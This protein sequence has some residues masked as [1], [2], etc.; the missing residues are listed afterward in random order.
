[1]NV[2]FAHVIHA[3]IQ[4]M[5]IMAT[6][7][8]EGFGAGGAQ[9]LVRFASQWQKG[10]LDVVADAL[11]A[12]GLCTE[13]DETSNT[14]SN[15]NSVGDTARD[16]LHTQTLSRTARPGEDPVRLC[17]ARFTD[18]P[19][20]ITLITVSWPETRRYSAMGRIRST[21]GDGRP[22]SHHRSEREDA[23]RHSSI[24]PRCAQRTASSRS[25]SLKSRCNDDRLFL[26]ELLCLQR[27]AQTLQ[28][29]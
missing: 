18:C 21:Y 14:K 23:G 2:A 20:M 8:F 1:V 28:Y 29:L 4:L 6:R 19:S 12:H 22:A 25:P 3:G 10:V 7:V 27:C 24:R 15:Y 11:D 17:R 5:E 16:L 26:W 13:P 9:V